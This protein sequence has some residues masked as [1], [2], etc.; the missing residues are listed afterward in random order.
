LA[1]VEFQDF[2]V[3]RL[4][5]G[6]GDTPEGRMYIYAE[7]DEKLQLSEQLIYEMY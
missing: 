2:E 4:G 3:F 5:Y 6:A 1:D 7:F